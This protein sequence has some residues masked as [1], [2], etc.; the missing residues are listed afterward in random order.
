[1]HVSAPGAAGAGELPP[2]PFGEQPAGA[3]AVVLE[4]AEAIPAARQTRPSQEA[5]DG[6]R[7]YL[8]AELAGQLSAP[9][10]E[11]QRTPK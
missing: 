6:R 5:L 10:I 11:V 7:G 8:N 1:V 9:M 2:G 3:R 4:Q